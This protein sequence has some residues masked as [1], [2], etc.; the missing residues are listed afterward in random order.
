MGKHS[1]PPR[2]KVKARGGVPQKTSSAAGT[3]QERGKQSHMAITSRWKCTVPLGLPV[4]PEVK[5][6]NATSS[7]AVSA[8]AKLPGFRAASAAS[9]WAASSLQYTPDVSMDAAGLAGFDPAA[10]RSSPQPC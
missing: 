7:A 9:E 2:P 8:F 1:I 6:I 4:V 10:K 5:A 3:R